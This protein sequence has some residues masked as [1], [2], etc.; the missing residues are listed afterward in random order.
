MSTSCWTAVSKTV[1]PM[2][3][4][5]MTL[6][7]VFDSTKAN[8]TISSGSVGVGDEEDDEEEKE[9]C[10]NDIFHVF[11]VMTMVVLQTWLGVL[12]RK[13]LPLAAVVLHDHRQNVESMVVRDNERSLMLQNSP[14]EKPS[15]CF[16]QKNFAFLSSPSTS[17][18]GQKQ[19]DFLRAFFMGLTAVYF[20]GLP[21]KTAKHV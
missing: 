7:P 1:F 3:P 4:S 17:C 14:L 11:S 12:H 6:L 21:Q 19:A 20:R 13:S 15:T 5:T 10:P 2:V 16:L 9:R 8:V 18:S